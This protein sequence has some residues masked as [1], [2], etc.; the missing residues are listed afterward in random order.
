MVKNG[1]LEK[2]CNYVNGKCKIQD[3]LKNNGI[4]N[5]MFTLLR[6]VL[7]KLKL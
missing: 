4:I 3:E 2:I 7:A 1:Q 5:F 6:K